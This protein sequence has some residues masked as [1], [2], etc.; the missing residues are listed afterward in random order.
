MWED[1]HSDDEDET[2]DEDE[3]VSSDSDS[4]V[5][6]EV[7]SKKDK[8]DKNKDNKDTKEDN[9]TILNKLKEMN[10]CASTKMLQKCIDLVENDIN[11]EEFV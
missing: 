5:E 6:N 11:Q 3:Q 9:L 10:N 4:E 1:Y 2:E 8:K 7:I